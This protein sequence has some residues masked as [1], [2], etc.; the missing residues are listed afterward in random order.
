M[1]F[2]VPISIC[3]YPRELSPCPHVPKMR[4]YIGDVS[5]PVSVDTYP[6]ELTR[7]PMRVYRGVVS[8]LVSV[9]IYPR[10]LSPCPHV[11][12]NESV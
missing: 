7:V 5:V 10:E 11:P 6:R 12:R 1:V 2:Y 8:V 3:I 4:V 9:G